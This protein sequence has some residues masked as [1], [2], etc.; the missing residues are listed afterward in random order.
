[1]IH[2]RDVLVTEFATSI[3][4]GCCRPGRTGDAN[5]PSVTAHLRIPLLIVDGSKDRLSCAPD[6]TDCSSAATLA[7]AEQ[8]F[9]PDTRVDAILIPDAG[10]AIN[11]HLNAQF[12]YHSVTSWIDQN[13]GTGP[14]AG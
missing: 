14:L 4:P 13:V 3:P 7:A 8:P 10:H 6:A 2:L 5:A 1:M 12:A 9:Y 11:L